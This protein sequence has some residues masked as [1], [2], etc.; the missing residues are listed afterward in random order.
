MKKNN[1]K[2]TITLFLIFGILSIICF[3]GCTSQS[4]LRSTTGSEA[5]DDSTRSETSV[6]A[7]GT[8]SLV[9][10]VN[11][12]SGKRSVSLNE[13]IT[14]SASAVDPAGGN[15]NVSWQ[16]SDGT[17][18]SQNGTSILWKAPEYGTKALVRC[19]AKDTKGNIG[20]ATAEITVAGTNQL[21]IKVLADKSSLYIDSD[22]ESISDY[23]PLS[24][25]KAQIVGSGNS[26]YSDQNGKVVLDIDSSLLNKEIQIRLN[27][28]N[29]DIT[30]SS[31]VS[32]VEGT[33]QNDEVMF[34][35]G[36]ENITVAKAYG[37]SFSMKTGKI[38]IAP[39]EKVSGVLKP[40]YE[41]TISAGSITTTN[42]SVSGKLLVSANS[43]TSTTISLDKSGYQA[44]ESYSIPTETAYATLV[45]AQLVPYT[46]MSLR[47]EPSLSSFKPGNYSRNISLS[48]SIVMGFAQPMTQDS[49]FNDF[50]AIVSNK[51]SNSY[52]TLNSTSISD[53]FSIEWKDSLNLVL[54]PKAAFNPDTTYAIEIKKW[55]A[56]AA[57]GRQLKNYAGFYRQFSTV[58]NPTPHVISYR[59]VNNERNVSRS[60]AFSITFDTIMDI[61]T[62]S[63]NIQI[64]VENRSDLTTTTINSG[65]L[66]DYA[67]ISW[68]NENKTVSFVPKTPLSPHAEYVFKIIK[69]GTK[70]TAGKTVTGINNTWIGF[71][72]SGF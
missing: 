20:S 33:I 63:N 39:V 43:G 34:S 12:A 52:F 70:S 45:Q 51:S 71:S 18:V 9:P 22:S 14:L 28:K 48:S 40:I 35:P 26:V 41:T 19:I 1:I 17:I 61:D 47:A 60:G 15:V 23:V 27:Y 62:L 32:N 42:D 24:G 67:S 10:I 58:N 8:T 6:V 21:V 4:M 7:S 50:E 49:I 64:E 5:T 37:D 36:Y 55:I 44:I 11:I 46:E 13:E 53:Y 2:P 3:S 66:N 16:A 68:S 38:E 69:L 57:D 65:N 29:W 56:Y 31:L 30:Y 59:P 25:A 54:I 72:T